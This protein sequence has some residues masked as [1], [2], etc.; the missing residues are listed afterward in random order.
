MEEGKLPPDENLAGST[1]SPSTASSGMTLKKSVID[2]VKFAD[3][4]EQIPRDSTEN[5]V[6]WQEPHHKVIERYGG[7]GDD[8]SVST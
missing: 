7:P 2:E 6:E 8:V 5:V 1:K 4:V 3:Q